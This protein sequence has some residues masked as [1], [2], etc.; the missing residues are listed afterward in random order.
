MKMMPASRLVTEAS[1]EPPSRPRDLA[2]SRAIT[3]LAE[4]GAD[5]ASVTA[6]VEIPKGLRTN[7]A[8][9]IA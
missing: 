4:A 2:R 5:C 6:T 9:L 8:I 1:L 7:A 3:P